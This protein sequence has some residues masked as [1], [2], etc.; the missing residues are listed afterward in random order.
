MHPSTNAGFTMRLP[1]SFLVCFATMAL[2]LRMVIATAEIPP[3]TDAPKP[4]SPE[5]SAEERS[6][7]QAP[8]A[9]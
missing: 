7:G 2:L 9:E 8:A 6:R 4:L 1:C 3:A 5:E